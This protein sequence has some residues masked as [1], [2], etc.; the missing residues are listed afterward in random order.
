MSDPGETART[1]D[2]GRRFGNWDL[3]CDLEASVDPEGKENSG[4]PAVDP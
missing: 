3:M 1:L 4:K 2:N